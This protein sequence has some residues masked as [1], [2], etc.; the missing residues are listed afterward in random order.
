VIS[1]VFAFAA[2]ESLDPDAVTLS[3][4]CTVM[5]ALGFPLGSLPMLPGATA[6]TQTSG[7]A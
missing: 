6:V 7:N 2:P 4:T 5:D 3:V 1:A